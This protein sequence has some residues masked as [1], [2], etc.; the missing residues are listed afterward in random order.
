MPVIDYLLPLDNYNYPTKLAKKYE[1]DA[2][3]MIPLYTCCAFDFA[4]YGYMLFKMQDPEILA[5]KLVTAMY[6]ISFA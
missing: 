4:I 5:S 3:F 6:I 2:R 1:K